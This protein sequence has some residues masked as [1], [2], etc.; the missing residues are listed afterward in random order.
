MPD[1]AGCINT[2]TRIMR[3]LL[4]AIA[5]EFTASGIEGPG[6]SALLIMRE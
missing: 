5:V 6:L 3:L 4:E 1:D 2:F